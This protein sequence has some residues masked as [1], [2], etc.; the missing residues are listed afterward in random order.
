MKKYKTTDLAVANALSLFEPIEKI[1]KIT[2]HK[3][4][5]TFNHTKKLDSLIKQYWQGKLRVEPANYFNQLK[6]NKGRI[7]E[8]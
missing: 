6:I 1:E 4:Q 8:I 2:P 7:Y 5:F 3:A